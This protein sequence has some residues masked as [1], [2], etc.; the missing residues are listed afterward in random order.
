VVRQF[1]AL[2]VIAAGCQ[3]TIPPYTVHVPPRLEEI[4]PP[5]SVVFVRAELPMDGLEAAIDGVL[6][7][8]VDGARKLSIGFLKDVELAWHLK[9]RPTWV[10][11][12][13]G[14]LKIQTF[15]YGE[16]DATVHGAHCH[17]KEA[18]VAF[19][20]S[21]RP[22][23]RASGELQLGDL[24]L[25]SNPTGNFDCS[26]LPFALPV[27]KIVEAIG[28]PAHR[29]LELALEQLRI[30]LAPVVN[31]ALD[32]LSQPR[33]VDL[34]GAP[35]CLDVDARELVLSPLGDDGGQVVV[36]LGVEAA[37][38]LNLGACV[39]RHQA[40]RAAVAETLPLGELFHVEAALAL[41]YD[42][43]TARVRPL[44]VGQSLG[45]G[46][47]RVTIDELELGDAD[48]RVLARVRVHGAISGLLYLWGTPAV[49]PDGIL[50]VPDLQAAVETKSALQKIRLGIWQLVDGGLREYLKKKLTLDV[51]ARLAE[52][53][54]W[55]SRDFALGHGLT[56][57]VEIGSITAGTA[58]SQTGAVVLHPI[59]VGRA[60]VF[61][62][63]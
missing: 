58:T 47:D 39:A 27:G 40:P 14:G 42:E 24:K 23:L 25:R 21:A 36:K 53:R 60:E 4:R 22:V 57:H 15:L 59:L 54:G 8:T 50:R 3:A 61:K 7:A 16:I 13:K 5:P 18:G 29:A 43:L 41:P 12:E 17:A 37:P 55:L 19:A 1:A 49:G 62:S 45:S 2:L 20:V 30:P 38:R 32:E 34:H 31:D 51:S 63:D 26:G 44:I 46:A 11:A 33:A 48:G 10:H 35:G 52:A 6:P 9:R 28:L 56:L